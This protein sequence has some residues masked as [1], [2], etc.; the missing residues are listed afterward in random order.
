MF[1]MKY[2]VS[3]SKPSILAVSISSI[4]WHAAHAQAGADPAD[5]AGRVPEVVVTA[6]RAQTPESGTP[7]SMSVLTGEQLVHAGF[8]SPATIGA[9]LPNVH[10]DG[11]ADGLKITIRG[12]S[13]ED[14][15][16]KGDPS[17]AFMLDGIYL[18]R[19]QNQN[20]SFHDIDRVEVLRG[21]QGTLY[22]RNTTAGAINVISNAPVQRF[23]GAVSAAVGNYASRKGSAMINVPVNDALALRAALAYNKHDSYLT[24]GQ[25]TP[26]TLG[27]DRDDVSSRV[28]AK[29]AFSR[30]AT[31]L[32]RYDHSTARDS[33]DS[34]VPDTNFY[35][36]DAA[37]NPVWYGAPTGERLA[38]RFVPPN[39][40][41]E[42]G[43]S[44]KTTSGLGAELTWNL[45]SA[46]LYY[47]GAHRNFDHDMLVN[48]YYRL[49]PGFAIGVHETFSGAYSQDS[50]ELRIATSGNGPVSAQAGVY[51][52]HEESNLLYAFR[53]LELVG[54]P[55][56]YVFPTTPT[57]ATSKAVFGQ[58]TWRV[59]D[60]LRLTAGVRRTMDDK[61]R[62]GSTNFQQGP[63]FNPATDLRL[64][65]AAAL[66][67]N[68]TTWRLGA[69]YDLARGTLLY[70]SVA[71]GY[72]AGGFNDGC[73]A[74]TSALGIDCPAAAAVPAST[75]FYQPETL[76]AYEL[77]LKSRFWDKRAS[78]NLA[79]F[80]YDYKNLQLSNVAIVQGAPRY[81]TSNAGAASI[82]GLEL[83][84][85][86]LP[87][88]RDRISYALTLLDGHYASYSPDGVHSWAGRKLDRSPANTV[89]LGYE[90]S[91][92][93]GNGQLVAGVVSRRSAAYEISVPTQL[94]QYPVPARTTT[95][96]TLSWHPR[97]AW[98]LQAQVRNLENKVQPL[99]I[100]SFGKLVPSDP[101][102]FE[103]R[104]DYRF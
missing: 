40:R 7:V 3:R 41:P 100:D 51:Y 104:A 75:L 81:V 80:D 71:T 99:T 82:K 47:V 96:L 57:R 27:L 11:A 18:A 66:E 38:N 48:H 17:A 77:G 94:L 8:D 29:L 92:P 68:K 45:G 21:P 13:N 79:A 25:G 54:L 15:T 86:V 72:K 93:V 97:A 44:H 95:D 16:D 23:E 55:P 33:D 73:L 62:V 91:V 36:S 22:G 43:Y 2:R 9:R 39:T 76:T 69:D 53:D 49:A 6:Q 14:T 65:N 58:A 59:Q 26:Y 46:T 87:T 4:V 32:L 19:P 90:H 88:A 12:I 61:S 30:D 1:L 67:T 89:T 83:D 42:Q 37:G 31:L 20:L 74:G 24:N 103:L 60:A 101:R 52:F 70:G 35:R 64:L 10:L 102:T 78:V 50:H 56:Y 85:L 5:A 84:G 34:A 98:S 28:S 63:V